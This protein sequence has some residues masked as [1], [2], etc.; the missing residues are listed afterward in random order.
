MNLKRIKAIGWIMVAI[1]V[2]CSFTLWGQRIQ[3]EE[4]Y[5]N[6]QM[7][8]N[9]S[10]MEA[11]ANANNMTMAE[12]GAEMQKRGVYGILYKEWSIGDLANEGRLSLQLGYNI[13]NTPYQD[14]ISKE[15]DVNDATL[16]IALLD[17]SIEAQVSENVLL[18]V[19]GARFYPGDISVLALP[20]MVP[21]GDG[22][23]STIN[24]KAKAVGV[25]FD[26]EAIQQMADMGFATVPQLR[27]WDY[28]T[29]Q[30]LRQVADD[31]KSMPNLA[32][33][34]FNDKAVPGYPDSIRTF[35]DLLKDTNGQTLVSI[36]SIEFSEQNG[37]NTL[38]VLLNKD[39]VRLHTISNGEM[40]KFTVNS[41]V[42][43]WLLAARER[44]MRCLLVRFFDISAPA[45]SLQNN[46]DYLETLQNELLA[47]GFHL[48]QAYEKPD[49]IHVANWMLYLIGFGVAAGLMLL[50]AEMR[51]PKLGIVGMVIAAICWVGLLHVSPIMA[52]KLMSLASV[53]I[54]PTLSCL[55]MMK[56]GRK[57]VPQ[58]VLSLLVMCG[59]SYIG[60]VLMV[61]MMAD[62]LFML[63]LDQFSGVKIAHVIPI[64]V[65]PFVLFI[66][67]TEKPYA[68]IQALLKKTLDYKWTALFAIIGIA[69]LIYISRTGNTTAEL[70]SGEAWMRS[71][72]NSV[73]GVRPRT[74]EFLI[75]Y[76]FAL[77]LFWLGATNRK[78]IFTIPAVI[79]QVSLVNTYAHIHTALLISVQRSAE[80][81]VIGIVIGLL[82]I[83]ATKLLLW[84]CRKIE[85]KEGQ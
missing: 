19:P 85:E 31:V 73:L 84:T 43:R 71:F 68:T 51:L 69:G 9:Y 22:D 50:L 44:N 26:R 20:V 7:I 10:D 78:W 49:S 66:W 60:A 32:Y 35:A 3:S 53:I 79:G 34:L 56:P 37:L 6:V 13:C 61:G 36:G 1:A 54:F 2:V 4:K 8:V 45:V 65:V 82:L 76:P 77:L 47:A 46:L 28:A 29:D 33:L 39:L 67:N 17:Q 75:G 58:A 5:K 24:T 42:D 18:K 21:N 62:V 14:R 16:Y 72:L 11:F 48:D 38:G 30:S 81:L 80:G 70:S 23:V 74:K 27:S 25:G 41:A 15:I 59:L 52:K 12:I 63:K 83:F 57:S 40:S 55:I 64:V